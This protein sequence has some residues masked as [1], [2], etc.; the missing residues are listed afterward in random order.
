[1][2][3]K[4]RDKP[5]I[6]TRIAETFLPRRGWRRGIEYIAHRL[7]RLPDT[8]HRIALGFACGV[9]SSFTPFFGLHLIGAIAL[10]WVLRANMISAA[11]GQLFGNPFTL[12]FIAWISMALG[13][14]ILGG[15]ATGRD[16]ERV[17]D[18][19]GSAAAGLWQSILS[20]FGMGQPQW[21][22]LAL[23]FT[24]VMLPYFVGGLLPG[25]V[26]AI[27]FYYLVRPLVAAYQAARRHRRLARA[28]ARLAQ[29]SGADAPRARPYKSGGTGSGNP[30]E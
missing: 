20:L 23:L 12:P 2:V 18:A 22:K 15:G 26:T 17:S 9:F 1:M 8:P 13:R 14:R 28:A 11:I 16:F 29:A 21:S 27:A 4:R 30:A 25:I 7:R 19:F 10:A 24:D 3:F 5:P 6:L